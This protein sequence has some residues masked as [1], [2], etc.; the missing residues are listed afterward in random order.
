MDVLLVCLAG[1]FGALLLW[2]GPIWQV[3]RL[4]S[5]QPL[6]PEK[7]FDKENEARRTL[8]QILGGFAILTAFYSTLAGVS[9]TQK[10]LALT[11]SGQVTDRFTTAIT[12]LA[13]AKLEERLGGAH[14]L[15]RLMNDS[16]GDRWTIAQILAVYLKEHAPSQLV[17]NRKT[18]E[19]G[20]LE[21]QMM[22]SIVAK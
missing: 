8:G 1:V 3:S 19:I 16:P 4:K 21:I 14:S 22:A 12:Q 5:R 13:S 18:T 7:V 10:Q 17:L 11:E 15:G 9:T 6:E 2:F 20:P